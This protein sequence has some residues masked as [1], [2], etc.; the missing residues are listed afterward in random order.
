[1][2]RPKVADPRGDHGISAYEF[3][4]ESGTGGTSESKK[5]SHWRLPG[6]QSREPI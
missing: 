4:R 3:V 5:D 2:V 6:A 1:M